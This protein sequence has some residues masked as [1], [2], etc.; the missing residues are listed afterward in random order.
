MREGPLPLRHPD[1]SVVIPT[2]G[3][4][5]LAETIRVL[6][7]GTV[8]PAEVL[9]CIPAEVAHRTEGLQ[10]ANVRV[11]RTDVRGQVPQRAAGFRAARFQFVMQIDDDMVVDARCVELLLETLEA[12]GRNAAVAPALVDLATGES[13]YRRHAKPA[14]MLR[15]YDWMMNGPSGYEPGMVDASGSGVGVD[16]GQAAGEPME[17]E[18]LPGGCVMHWRENL[19]TEDFYPLPGKAYYED[20]FHSFHL[21]RKGCR[22]ILDVRAR[23]ALETMPASTTFTLRQFLRH[24]RDD[25][26]A[27][28][29]YVR[30]TSRS[31]LRMH[32]FYLFYCMSYAAKRLRAGSRSR[33]STHAGGAV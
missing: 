12:Y 20:L 33:G 16:A 19:V 15:F 10:F 3:G 26:R 8:V 6:N 31:V 18:W 25:Y 17:V 21:R 32:A 14:A 9:V 5:S 29:Y 30:L 7:A 24:I 2:L 22:L 13:V 23:C 28:R 11:L 27:R 4:P 1:V